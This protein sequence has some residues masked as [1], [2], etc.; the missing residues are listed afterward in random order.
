MDGKPDVAAVPFA[1]AVADATGTEEL[2]AV[3]A[4]PVPSGVELVRELLAL[5]VIEAVPGRLGIVAEMLALF[6]GKLVDA[7][8]GAPPA[9]YPLHAAV[10]PGAGYCRPDTLVII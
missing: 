5:A 3:G 8:A 7:A 6:T 10:Q 9:Q 2:E 1:E 4:M